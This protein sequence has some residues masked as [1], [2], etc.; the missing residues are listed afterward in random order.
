M[1]WF[2]TRVTSHYSLL[3]STLTPKVLVSTAKSFGYNSVALTDYASVSGAIQFIKACKKEEI[4][5]IIGCEIPVENYGGTI[6]VLCKNKEAWVKLLK[7]VSICNK[8]EGLIF[9]SESLSII[10][11]DF[12]V[13]DGYIGSR[14]FYHMVEDPACIHKAE[15]EEEAVSCLDNTNQDLVIQKINDYVNLFGGNYF[16]ELN[17]INGKEFPSSNAVSDYL[18]Q[19]ATDMNFSNLV[20]GCPINYAKPEDAVDHRLLLSSKMK[21]TSSNAEKGL[22]KED[23]YKFTKFFKSNLYCFPALQ[24]MEELYGPELLHNVSQIDEQ[25]ESY[26]ILSKPLLP[27]FDCPGG[28]SQIEYLKQLCR[29]GWKNI[30]IPQG[31]VK[32]NEKKIEYRDRVLSELAIIEEADLAGYFLIVADYVNQFR[33]NGRLIG[34]GR[35]TAAGSL[36]SYLVGITLIDPIPYGLLFSRFYNSARVGSL[37]D[38][39][40]DFPPDLR[41]EVINYLRE[42][43]GHDK[44][45]QMVTFGRLQGRGALKEVL[46]INE[47]CSFEEMN[48]ITN[49]IPLESL[50][51]DKLEEMEKPS[52]IKWCLEND[53][54]ALREY[55]V[56]VDGEL[57]GDYAKQFEQALRIEGI[58]KSQGKHAAGVV[59][60]SVPLEQFCPMVKPTKGEDP[61]AG[62]EMSDLEA[63]GGVKLDILGVNLLRKI[64]M[65]CQT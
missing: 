42:K 34:P 18:S 54:D 13:I 36:V 21:V 35:G 2:P 26:D 57:S 39:D 17:R 28:V 7:I 37:P 5:G 25:C 4:K 11:G 9:P 46:R 22:L 33:N 55:C 62:F 41:E 50:L 40:V 30:L 8:H 6:I 1:P 32:S 47:S 14:L 60:S 38:I 10:D 58:F 44:V 43:Y 65:V 52:V 15:T 56:E 19:I 3:Q 48:M 53:Q 20:A 29:E 64:E 16:L 49:K 59:V 12:F 63:A 45:C 27:T 61:V 31:V 51:S 23:F 24:K